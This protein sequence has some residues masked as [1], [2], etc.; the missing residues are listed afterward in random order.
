MQFYQDNLEQLKQ[1]GA[2]RQLRTI[3]SEGRYVLFNDKSYLNFSSNDYLGLSSN[4]PLQANFLKSLEGQQTFLFGSTS[5]RLLTGNFKEMSELEHLLAKIYKRES[6]LVFNSG[7]HANIGILPA[8]TTK[9]DLILADKFVHASIIDGLRLCE[10]KFERY[11]HNNID[12]LELLLKKHRANFDRI[13]I[14]TESV[15]SMD[16]DFA[17]LPKLCSLK[18]AYNAYLYVDEA[19]AFGVYGA[20]GLGLSEVQGCVERIDFIVGTFGKAIASHGAYVICHSVFREYLINTM[21]SLIFS[22][23]IAPINVMWTIHVVNQLRFFNYERERLLRISGDFRHELTKRG[24]ATKGSSQIVPLISGENEKCLQLSD[25]LKEA[26]YWAL[27]VRYP[28]VPK[29]EARIRFSFRP[30]IT[31]TEIDNLTTLLG[32]ENS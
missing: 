23:A 11:Q 5:S 17:D 3:S 19:H 24:F 21:R 9:K 29:G 1:Q 2:Y 4:G 22:T 7:Y 30:D 31:D 25:K 28:T 8:L 13:F 16:G 15:F 27:P 26:G 12:H 6:A 18:E 20:T 14:V 10:A 32:N